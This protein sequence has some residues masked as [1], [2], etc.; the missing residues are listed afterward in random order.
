MSN[1]NLATSSSEEV[2]GQVSLPLARI[3]RIIH[4]DDDIH[5]C[6]NNAAFTITIATQMFIQY[7][8]EQAHN[9]VK[10]ERK[11]RRNIQYKDIANAVAR[12]DNLEFLSDVVPKTIPYK[13]L[14]EKKFDPSNGNISESSQAALDRSQVGRLGLDGAGYEESVDSDATI[15]QRDNM[16]MEIRGS[17]ESG[18]LASNPDEDA[19]V[20]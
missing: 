19:M 7:L 5:N 20:E 16:K 11:P 1:K 9:V 15:P 17:R 8:A 10:S 18:I 14:K 2:T 3:K 12:I 13:Q 4:V 6:S